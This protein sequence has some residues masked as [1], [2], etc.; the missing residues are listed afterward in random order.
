MTQNPTVQTTKNP[1]PSSTIPGS[2][3]KC[4]RRDEAIKRQRPNPT[5]PIFPNL[6]LGPKEESILTKKIFSYDTVVGSP[7]TEPEN[8]EM[9][10]ED[11]G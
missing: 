2:G 4:T 9:E 8:V 10:E 7:Q 3:S 5:L 6:P 11:N 1:N